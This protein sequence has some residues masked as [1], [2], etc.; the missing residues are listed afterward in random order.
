[1]QDRHSRICHHCE[2]QT[3]RLLVREWHSISAEGFSSCD[4][5]G[6]VADMLTEP[7]TRSLPISWQGEYSIERARHWIEERDEEGTT[8]LVLDRNSEQAVGLVILFEV[9]SAEP[10]RGIEV[11]IGYLLA[12]SAWGKGLGSELLQGLVEWSRAQPV[13]SSLAG[14]VDSENTASRRVLEKSGFRIV[15][16][17]EN[18]ESYRLTFRR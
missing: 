17:G 6:I 15:R 5:A 1:M 13:I 12:E 2:F 4:L 16:Q 3:Q 9:E 8:L 7:V 18:G 14:G 10:E 11:R